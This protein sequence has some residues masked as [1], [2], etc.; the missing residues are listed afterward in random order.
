M[1]LKKND[2]H[3]RYT[4]DQYD[5]FTAS[6]VKPFDEMVAWRV[7][8]EARPRLPGALLLDVGTGTARLLVHLARIEELAGL[9][10][11]GTDFFADMVERAKRTVVE[12]G[13][14]DR[15]ELIQQDV[16]AMSLPDGYA[17]IILSR[18]TLHHWADPPRALAE[19]YRVL[20]PGG[21]ALIHDVRR[22]PEP[23]ALAEFNRLREM[24][25]VG[26]SYLDEK[27]TSQEAEA[28]VREAGLAAHATIRAPKNGL[29][30]LGMEV[31]IIKPLS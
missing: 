20:R 18:S 4:A 9:H 6:F 24:A 26:P 21:I 19:I 5:Q 22:D 27:F 14:T 25:G 31:E 2:P 16:H 29:G 17:D 1:D 8:K 12:A 28:F 10:I 3:V 15:I 30:A 13:L 11:V 23:E 7:I